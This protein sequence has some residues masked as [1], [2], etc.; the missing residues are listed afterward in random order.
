LAFSV[1]GN[2]QAALV[3]YLDYTNFDSRLGELAPNAGITAFSGAEITSIKSGISSQLGTAY[4]DYTVTFQETNP[5][6]SY[7][8]VSFGLTAAAGSLGL[9]DS[10]DY[11][12][13][14][15]NQTARVY[16]ANFDFIVDEFSGSTSRSTQLSQLTAAL[17]GTAAHELAHNL[18]LRHHDAYADVTFTGSSVATGG[19][20]N[21]HIMATGST[22][23]G[24]TGRETERTFSE[25]SEVKLAYGTDLLASTP[26]SVFESGDAGNAYTLAQAVSLTSLSN[27]ARDA[28]N[29]IGGLGSSDVDYYSLSLAAGTTLTADI[30]EEALGAGYA[31]TILTF[32]DVN[33][34][35]VLGSNDDSLYSANTFG[36]GGYGSYDSILYN[37]PIGTTGTYYVGVT[38]YAGGSGYYQ[39]LLHT[40]SAVVP[41]PTTL[42][43]L[44]GLLGTSALFGWRRRRR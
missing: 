17:A 24:E 31:D 41:E 8:T 3:T 22:G 23:L 14:T 44:V 15:S 32:Y 11:R 43:G 29:I 10:I 25:N 5:G 1:A 7:E 42:V 30:N 39:L 4:A 37:V 20:Q 19:V 6:G 2:S 13:Q 16:S 27:V 9:A 26:S 21:D 34:T 38:G 12:N 18:G 33:G 35:T 40:D 36:S 28:A